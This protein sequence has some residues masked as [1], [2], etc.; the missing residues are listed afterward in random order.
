ME[1]AQQTRNVAYKP[2]LDMALQAAIRY[3]DYDVGML[4]FCH[5]P[6]LK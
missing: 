6:L 3:A 4:G 5:R 1:I 2:H